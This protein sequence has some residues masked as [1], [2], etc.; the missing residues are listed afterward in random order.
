MLVT[1]DNQAPKITIEQPYPGEILSAPKN[2]EFIFQADV[3]DNLGIQKVEFYL[4]GKIIAARFVSP[5][6]V[7]W[8]PVIGEHTLK[9]IAIDQAG[10]QTSTETTFT[11]Q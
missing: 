7:T 8:R 11:I 5:F 10:N 4:D 6:I 9:I 2:N 3:Q 1:I